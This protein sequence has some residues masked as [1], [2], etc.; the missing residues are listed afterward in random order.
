V[1][2]RLA[3]LGGELLV[4]ALDRLAEGSLTFSEQDESLATYAEKIAPEERRLDPSRPAAEL[5]RRVRALNPHIGTHVEL[6][7]GEWLGVLGAR[8]APE[9]PPQGEIATGSGELLLGCAE[10]ALR[11]EPVQPPGGRAM[12]AADFLR[13]HPTPSRAL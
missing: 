2:A 4:R 7:G 8:A 1:S 6:E 10:G 3:E 9:G 12:A 11:L 13:G 5:E